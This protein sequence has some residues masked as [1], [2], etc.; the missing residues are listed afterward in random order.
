MLSAPLPFDISGHHHRTLDDPVQL[1]S[2]VVHIVQLP[3]AIRMVW[4]GPPRF[5]VSYL[6]KLDDDTERGSLTWEQ[7]W[8]DLGCWPVISCEEPGGDGPKT[9]ST[10]N[11]FI[12]IVEALE[13]LK[14][15]PQRA[16]QAALHLVEW[17]TPYGR[18]YSKYFPVP[19]SQM[20]LPPGSFCR[21]FCDLAWMPSIQKNR[22]LSA[23]EGWINTSHASGDLPNDLL[24]TTCFDPA[25]ENLAKNWIVVP[26][27]KEKPTARI[28]VRTLK[29][30]AGEVV[31]IKLED[32]LV[33]YETLHFAL[34]KEHIKAEE[35][36]LDPAEESLDA[37][38]VRNFLQ[39]EPWIFLPH[40]QKRHEA[41]ANYR[42]AYEGK[43]YL[44]SRAAI[45]DP[46]GLFSNTYN[47]YM[48]EETADFAKKAVSM[49]TLRGYYLY[50]ASLLEGKL[51]KQQK[52]LSALFRQWG[53]AKKIGWDAYLGV[54]RKVDQ[55]VGVDPDKLWEKGNVY[56]KV[57]ASVVSTLRWYSQVEEHLREHA[58]T[59]WWA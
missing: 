57:V 26:W 20:T 34:S 7:F 39:N 51:Q 37:T 40:L 3:P 17:L 27:V 11:D 18:F 55:E 23:S 19:G 25:V 45:S 2:T 43:L 5:N 12:C 38:E 42:E 54:L 31:K 6:Y 16:Q 30:L 15:N 29:A 48:D 4:K 24:K 35:E 32:A 1:S 22:L 58:G 21:A 46:T 47:Q 49:Q 56:S 41:F 33:F 28:L 10:S 52:N 53:V 14:S 59:F 8:Q 44:S 9:A 13:Q 36:Q 50:D